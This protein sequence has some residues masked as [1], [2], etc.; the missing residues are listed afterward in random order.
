MITSQTLTQAREALIL[1]AEQKHELQVQVNAQAR[2][3]FELEREVQKLASTLSNT[4]QWL[5]EARQEI[6]ALRSQLPDDA[7]QRAFDDLTQYLTA[8]SE[9]RGDMRLAA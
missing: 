6:S 2:K 9:V 3:I 8:P 7:T 4:Q 1:S 5:T